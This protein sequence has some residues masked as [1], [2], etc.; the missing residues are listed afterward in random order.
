MLRIW[1]AIVRSLPRSRDASRYFDHVIKH[2]RRGNLEVARWKAIYAAYLWNII[3]TKLEMGAKDS[4]PSF[5]TYE[6]A[7]KR[8][9][10]PG[11][12]R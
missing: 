7:V 6:D 3:Q 9:E 10:W 1:R 5:L 2:G 12:D 8:G 4:K 11:H